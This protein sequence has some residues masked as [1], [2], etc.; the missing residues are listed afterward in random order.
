MLKTRSA[1]QGRYIKRT[2]VITFFYLASVAAAS[3]LIDKQAPASAL[4]IILAILPGLAIAAIFW[5]IG[6]LIVEEQDEFV[7]MLIVRQSLIATGFAL[8][9]ASVWGFLEAYGVAPHIDAYWVAILW[10]LGLA[11]GAVANKIQYGTFGECA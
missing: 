11:V 3:F 7:R 4:T 2:L 1:A 6:R 9:L 10:F 8:S 5:S